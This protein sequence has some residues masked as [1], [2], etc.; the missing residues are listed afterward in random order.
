M[1]KIKTS[2]A[3]MIV[4]IAAACGQDT[5]LPDSHQLPPPQSFDSPAPHVGMPANA[6][7]A[8]LREYCKACHGVGK[9]R[10]IWTESDDELWDYIL[11][12]QAPGRKKLWAAAIVE[13]LS[14]PS[15]QPPPALPV[16]DPEAGRDWMPKGGKRARMAS[17]S[18]DGVPVRRFIIDALNKELA[19]QTA[20]KTASKDTVAE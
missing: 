3:A 17:D 12:Q 13:V 18:I 5:G 20:I 9:L 14:W 7:A 8:K 15:D 19:D 16:M 11:T 4:L 2:A 1:K 6:S 10:F